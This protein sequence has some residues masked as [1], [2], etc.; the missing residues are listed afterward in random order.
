MGKT[1][2]DGLKVAQFRNKLG[3][4]RD[5][6]RFSN[7]FNRHYANEANK[8]RSK[9][10]LVIETVGPFDDLLF[11]E[12]QICRITYLPTAVA[13]NNFVHRH[14]EARRASLDDV[15]P[16]PAANAKVAIGF[17]EVVAHQFSLKVEQILKAWNFPGECRVYYDKDASDFVID[18]KPRGSRGK[19]LRAITHAAVSITLLEYCQEHELPHPGFLLLD[20]PLL[21]YFKPEGDEDTALQGTDLKER[22]YGYLK[23][24]HGVESQVIIIENQ[25][26]PDSEL[27]GLNLTV[28]TRNPAEGRFGLL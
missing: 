2:A 11:D 23:A 24:H 12:F 19:G 6:Y 27:E 3:M 10:S 28:F 21:A 18:G 22:F 25:H 15:A 7:F 1:V 20:S 9:M 8:H 4:Y 26:P 13:H 14:L 16:E 17:S 5:V